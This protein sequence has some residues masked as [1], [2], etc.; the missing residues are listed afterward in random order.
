MYLLKISLKRSKGKTY[1]VFIP[2]VPSQWPMGFNII[3][4][5]FS[6]NWVYMEVIPLSSMI[7][8]IISLG[9]KMIIW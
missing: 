2:I 9:E 4:S 6:I 3:L 5:K 8:M 7:V 1:F